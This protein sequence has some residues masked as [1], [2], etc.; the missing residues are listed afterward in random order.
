M[1]EARGL[2]IPRIMGYTAVVLA[3]LA[4]L[5]VLYQLGQVVLLFILS[6]IVAAALRK[7]VVAL[8]QRR[9]PRGI[10]ILFWYLVVLAVLGLG[11]YVLGGALGQE[12]QAISNTFPQRYDVL[13]GRYQTGGARWQQ[14]LAQRLPT[15]EMVIQGLGEGGATEIGFQIA[16]LTYGIANIGVSILAIL[17][18]TF[19]WLIDQ[20]RFERLWLTLLPVQQ[21]AIARHA[22]R[23]IEQQVGAYVR[24][25]AAQFVLTVAV[26]WLAFRLLG[27]TY[28]TLYALFAGVV[29]LIPWVGIPLTLL[30]LGLML[31]ADPWWLVLATG[32][33]IG[34]L[35]VLMDRFVEPKLCG[36]APVHPILVVIALM[37]LGEAS[38]VLGM[39]IALPLAATL[40][41]VLAELIRVSTAP[42]AT[43]SL[44]EATQ[45][46]DLQ[47]R[48]ERLRELLPEDSADRREA[49]NIVSRVQDLL[50]RTEEVVRERATSVE[51]TRMP[52][53][54]RRIP[55]IVQG[56]KGS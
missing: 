55:A 51:R 4:S 10:A 53:H 39:L 7:G 38:G 22:W 45:L 40:Q 32:A 19:Y 36:N 41:I 12:L 6:I 5:F 13:I 44:I 15:T 48:I 8:K 27:V 49:E 43:T 9:L 34:V 54:R 24:S 35:G 1:S 25:E 42:K 14:A 28:P 29:Q 16:G 20:N 21:R 46:Q 50:D 3:T 47:T 30:P 26:L 31:F 23:G 11:I 17:T 37:I 56:S 18:L 33:V 2:S 52:A